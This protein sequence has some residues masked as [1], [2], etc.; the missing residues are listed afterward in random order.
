MPGSEDLKSFRRF[1]RTT[2]SFIVQSIAADYRPSLAWMAT[3][4]GSATLALP[5]A[6]GYYYLIFFG[7]PG[8]SIAVA[9]GNP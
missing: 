1:P 7:Q 3:E 9:V 6:A 5:A 2:S 8:D 4:Q